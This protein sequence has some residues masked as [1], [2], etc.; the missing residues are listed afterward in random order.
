M[1]ISLVINGPIP[2]TAALRCR[3]FLGCLGGTLASCWRGTICLWNLRHGGS[4]R[5]LAKPER[6]N[7]WVNPQLGFTW[8]RCWLGFQWILWVVWT[9]LRWLMLMET[10]PPP[11][12]MTFEVFRETLRFRVLYLKYGWFL[13]GK[14]LASLGADL[15][16]LSHGVGQFEPRPVVFDFPWH[17]SWLSWSWLVQI[18]PRRSV[19]ARKMWWVLR[20]GSF[21]HGS[22]NMIMINRDV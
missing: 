7:P 4:F 20:F 3:R 9:I 2:S 22:W 17:L 8:I 16:W 19:G 11:K 15:L 18:V 13:G 12:K 14:F 10:Q 21:R 6:E 1:A 5:H